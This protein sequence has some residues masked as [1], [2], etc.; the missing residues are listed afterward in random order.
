MR[1]MVDLLIRSGIPH[2]IIG[3]HAIGVHGGQRDTVDFDCIVAAERRDE[4]T[5]FL[6]SRGFDETARH[7][8]FSR[9]RHRSLSYPLLDVME[10]D[11]DVW[12]KMWTESVEK[13]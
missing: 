11:S 10:V 1:E 9:F 12:Q 6:Q 7:G 8:S 13:S 4:M 3:G 5:K 2:L